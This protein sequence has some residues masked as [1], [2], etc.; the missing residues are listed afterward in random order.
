MSSE[1]IKEYLA[2]FTT[3]YGATPSSGCILVSR[4]LSSRVGIGRQPAIYHVISLIIGERTIQ[5]KCGTGSMTSYPE[6]SVRSGL[7]KYEG[8]ASFALK[9]THNL[10]SIKEGDIY[11]TLGLKYAKYV[12]DMPIIPLEK[13][14]FNE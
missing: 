8:G 12:G 14:G 13:L 3:V 10:L 9:I 4:I 1:K 11:A 6:H 5:V 2:A 7:I